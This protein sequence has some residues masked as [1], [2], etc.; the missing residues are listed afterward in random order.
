MSQH[1]ANA[2]FVK[3]NWYKKQV[4]LSKSIENCDYLLQSLSNASIEGLPALIKIVL[5]RYQ[6]IM[7]KGTLSTVGLNQP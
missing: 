3:N 2:V 7:A 6:E 4:L 5:I 1:R